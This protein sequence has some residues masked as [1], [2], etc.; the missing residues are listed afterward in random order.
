MGRGLWGGPSG[1]G[2]GGKEGGWWEGAQPAPRQPG[3]VGGGYLQEALWKGDSSH[4]R[5][6]LSHCLGV[7][8][9]ASPLHPRAQ[10]EC[11]MTGAGTEGK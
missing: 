11:S 9:A 8:V 10:P 7:T 1:Q 4:S 3:G 5:S 6:L 2:A